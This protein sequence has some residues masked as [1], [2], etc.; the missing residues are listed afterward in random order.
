MKLTKQIVTVAV[1]ALMAAACKNVKYKKTKEG[2]LY[3][4]YDAGSGDKI[5]PGNVIRFHTTS[6]IGD[7]LLGTSYGNPAQFLPIPDNAKEVDEIKFF[8]EARK[9]DSILLIR[10]IDT[11][12]AKNPQA[13]A[14]DSFLLKNRG[15]EI[16]TFVKI[17]EVYKSKEEA[18]AIQEK[19]GI[20][21]F[22][23]D[24]TNAKQ[25]A[26]DAAAIDAYLKANN[27]TNAKKT[28]MGV[29]VQTLKPGNGQKAKMGEYMM[30]R[31]TGKGFDG[32]V[33][34][35][36]VDNGKPVMPFQVGAGGMI[37]GFAD[38]AKQLSKGEK[39]IVVIPSQFAYG[40]QGNPPVIQPNQNLVFELEVVD[41][42]KT[43]PAPP[44]MPMPDTPRK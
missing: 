32:K 38:G 44:P 14:Q 20:D 36:N 22:L 4:I 31:Y 2:Y 34:D 40:A 5:A 33:F 21:N 13:A 6:K 28:A 37:P 15:K 3:T 19:E 8:L 7:S 18:A 26:T 23:K 39:A 11:I 17:V 12:I 43:A 24:P 41:I 9:G 16:R 25:Y 10:S 42:S 27:Y 29:A 35:S 30:L 1:I